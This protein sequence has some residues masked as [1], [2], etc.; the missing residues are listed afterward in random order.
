MA[1]NEVIKKVEGICEICNINRYPIR[2]VEV[3]EKHGFTVFEEYLKKGISGFI[4]VSD[5]PI[6]KYNTNK[7]IVT[8]LKDFASRRRYTIAYELANYLLYGSNEDKCYAHK[9]EGR[10]GSMDDQANVFAINLLMPEKF[11]RYEIEEF[12]SEAEK[13]IQDALRV[14]YIA[15]KFA[16]SSQIAE[17]RLRQ[18]GLQ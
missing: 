3:C 2:I 1:D 14:H 9:N 12:E 4:I 8:N 15:K 11:V 13:N 10:Y 6:E 5:E 16:V 17:Y 7:V 18:L